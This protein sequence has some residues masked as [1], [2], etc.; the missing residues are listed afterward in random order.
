[1]RKYQAC[2]KHYLISMVLF[3][4]VGCSSDY[5][6]FWKIIPLQLSRVAQQESYEQ[7]FIIK[8]DNEASLNKNELEIRRDEKMDA[9]FS[10]MIG[11]NNWQ[12]LKNHY[13]IHDIRDELIARQIKMHG[14]INFIAYLDP[15]DKNDSTLHIV[16][17]GT[18]KYFAIRNS[19]KA[20]LMSGDFKI[21]PQRF[22]LKSLK[23]GCI[24]L[25]VNL[26]TTRIP[27]ETTYY[28]PVTMRYELK[29]KS[30][31]KDT[32]SIDYGIDHK[33]YLQISGNKEYEHIADIKFKG[34]FNHVK[35]FDL[36]GS[37][38]INN[39]YKVSD[40]VKVSL[41]KNNTKTKSNSCFK[42]KEQ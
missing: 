38:L 9:I 10:S 15:L 41:N 12:Y 28:H 42:N 7:S 39:R 33:G 29:M 13:G 24:A 2:F 14:M 32:Y 27:G 36:R 5:I 37:E 3:I 1:M 19:T 20:I 8:V 6:K 17:E 4:L 25:D 35:L 40:E 34:D 26:Y 11:N 23:E 16:L 31:A 30:K 18:G 22:P 21:L